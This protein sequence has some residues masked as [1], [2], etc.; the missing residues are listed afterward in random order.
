VS[1]ERFAEVKAWAVGHGLPVENVAYRELAQVDPPNLLFRK[2]WIEDRRAR[3]AEDVR[4][5]LADPRP[6]AER[7]PETL[8]AFLAESLLGK[9]ETRLDATGVGRLILK[10]P[11]DVQRALVLTALEALASAPIRADDVHPSFWG[12]AYVHDSYWG[13]L[14]KALLH[15]PLP[16]TEPFARGLLVALDAL[17][18]RFGEVTGRCAYHYPFAA[19]AAYLERRAA[20]W[21]A[22]L[23]PEVWRLLHRVTALMLQRHDAMQEA[24]REAPPDPRT[25]ALLQ[26]PPI[27]WEAVRRR[28]AEMPEEAF[29]AQD[30]RAIAT[31]HRWASRDPAG[32]AALEIEP[33]D[34]GRQLVGALEAAP[35]PMRVALTGLVAWLARGVAPAPPVRWRRELA[36]RLHDIDRAALVAWLGGLLP[37][38]AETELAFEPFAGRGRPGVGTFPGEVSAA[39]LLGLVQAAGVLG[40]DVLVP[41]VAAVLEA[42]WTPVP[43]IGVRAQSVGFACLP[44]LARSPVGRARLRSLRPRLKQRSLRQRIEAALGRAEDG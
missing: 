3:L 26:L 17:A 5:F 2:A 1:P 4:S 41:A 35:E 40:D 37:R 30:R 27:D 24:A 7:L 28:T 38:F 18:G 20:P 15:R 9:G 44:I 21:R 31:L 22:A 13:V 14:V 29:V 16:C 12:V 23:R 8:A 11:D 19:I 32:R 33:D 6:V 39:V 36:S 25:E 42:A 34:W 10:A 43:G